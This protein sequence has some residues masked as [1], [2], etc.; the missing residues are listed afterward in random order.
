M[1]P[2]IAQLAPET[3]DTV[4]IEKQNTKVQEVKVDNVCVA[5]IL[6]PLFSLNSGDARDPLTHSTSP[7]STL[8]RTSLLSN[9]LVRFRSI[10]MAPDCELKH[11]VPLNQ[12][13][14]ILVLGPTQRNL[15]S[16]TPTSPLTILAHTSALKFLASRYPN[17]QRRAWTNLLCLP[18]RGK[19]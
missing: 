9:S 16:S 14:S 15:I 5:L 2:S 1:A 13:M 3:V 6:I 7:T 19:F 12:T 18:L 10:S 11:T 4:Q 8:T 17:L